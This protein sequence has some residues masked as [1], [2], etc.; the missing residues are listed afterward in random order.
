MEKLFDNVLYN[1]EN[2]TFI[3]VN[4]YLITAKFFQC[5]NIIFVQ[6]VPIFNNHSFFMQTMYIYGICDDPLLETPLC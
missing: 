6:F 4:N 2:N 5:K 1:F 3:F